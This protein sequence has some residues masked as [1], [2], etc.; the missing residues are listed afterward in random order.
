MLPHDY[1]DLEIA[2]A[3]G[4]AVS[5]GDG[6]APVTGQVDEWITGQPDIHPGD[7]VPGQTPPGFGW[8]AAVPIRPGRW[9]LSTRAYKVASGD[10]IAGLSAT[11]LGTPQRLMEIWTLQ[12][13]TRRAKSSADVIW[14]EEWLSMPPDAE[15][16]LRAAVGLPQT[17]QGTPAPPPPGGYQIPGG[18]VDPYSPVGQELQA[19]QT[20][21]SRNKKL[22]LAGGAGVLGLA[23]LWALR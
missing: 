5:L 15:A 11:Y 3:F 18:A 6:Y 23:A 2:L 14:P 4:E 10:T 20:T 16:T 22:L 19:Q 1:S 9:D 12:S 17:G 13:G 8:P 21:S 7:P